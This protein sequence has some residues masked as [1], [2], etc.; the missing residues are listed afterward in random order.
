MSITTYD[1]AGANGVTEFSIDS[2][3]G[4]TQGPNVRSGTG[5][6][7]Q[8]RSTNSGVAKGSFVESDSAGFEWVAGDAF[9][10]QTFNLNTLYFTGTAGDKLV[11]LKF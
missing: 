6:W 4:P 3:G 2:D 5:F 10:I 1:V 8:A 7:I 11:A 9:P